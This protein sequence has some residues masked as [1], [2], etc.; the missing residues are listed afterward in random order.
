M[1]TSKEIARAHVR[2]LEQYAKDIPTEL[3]LNVDEAGR[4]ARA[5]RKKCNTVIYRQARDHTVEYVFSRKEKRMNWIIT[6][7]LG[8]VVMPL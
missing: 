2:N 8:E 6:I 7:S 1:K 3:I 5:D 4:P